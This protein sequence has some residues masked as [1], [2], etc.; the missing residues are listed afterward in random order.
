MSCAS[1][2]KA[3]TGAGTI[4]TK[5][6]LPR[7]RGH[8]TI[9]SPRPRWASQPPEFRRQIV[10]LVH[11]DR[12]LE[13]L[14]QELEPTAQ[15][16]RSWVGLSAGNAGRGQAAEREELLSKLGLTPQQPLQ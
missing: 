11:A 2:D 7:I 8:R 3:P 10:N 15:S 6:K 4:V 5:V 13:Q 14:A 16:I 1:V 12:S 9:L